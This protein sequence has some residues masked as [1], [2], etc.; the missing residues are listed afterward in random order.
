MAVAATGFFDGVHVGHRK[1]IGELCSLAREK[2][3]E[4]T[5]ISF[6]PHPRIVLGKDAG[7]LSLLNSLEE[8]RDLCKACGVDNFEVIPF[9]LEFSRLSSRE[10]LKLMRDEY[11]VTVM[12][13]G[14]D[15]RFGHDVVESPEALAEIVR[16][17]GIEPVRVGRLSSDDVAVSSTVIRRLLSAGEVAKAA[18]MLGYDYMIS[19]R[20]SYDGVFVPDEPLKLVPA[21]GRYVAKLGYGGCTFDGFCS[22]SGGIMRPERRCDSISFK[23]ISLELK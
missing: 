19:G 5:I 21:D 8:K 18:N 7:S 14:Y 4:S 2:G 12:V 15:H 9:T 10:F 20:T 17:C 22:I 13:L 3:Q 16:E 1:V 6:W 11:D 23:S